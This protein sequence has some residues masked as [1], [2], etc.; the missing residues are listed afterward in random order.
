MAE[1]KDEEEGKGSRHHAVDEAVVLRKL[2]RHILIKFF[3]MT[4]LCY[5]DRT[6][7]AFAALQLNRSLGFTEKVYGMG[8]G[9]FFLGYSMFQVRKFWTSWS[10]TCFFARPF[11]VRVHVGGT[12]SSAPPS[13]MC[14]RTVPHALIASAMRAD[15]QQHDPG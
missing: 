5:I 14:G 2:N 3:I 8:S 15:P 1:G 13:Q 9:V 4:V 11:T 7:L 10:S 6:N 12:C